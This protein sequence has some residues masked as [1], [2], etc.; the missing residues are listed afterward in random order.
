MV[1]LV[2]GLVVTQAAVPVGVIISIA[3]FLCMVGGAA[4]IIKRPHA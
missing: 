2:V 4:S 1:L 3:G